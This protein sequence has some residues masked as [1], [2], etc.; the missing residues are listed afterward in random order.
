MPALSAIIDGPIGPATATPR[1]AWSSA[2]RPASAVTPV[3]AKKKITPN[4][5]GSAGPSSRGVDWKSESG[6]AGTC[7]RSRR[8]P[9]FL[10]LI[11]PRCGPIPSRCG[12]IPS[13]CGPA[14]RRC[15]PALARRGPSRD[16]CRPVLVGCGPILA[17]CGPILARCGGVRPSGGEARP[18]AQAPELGIGRRPRRQQLQPA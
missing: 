13:R 3:P 11:P 17:R 15:A 8:R 9:P 12:P 18:L 10:R 14:T 2:T 1:A 6:P 7:R 5:P 16:R 4:L